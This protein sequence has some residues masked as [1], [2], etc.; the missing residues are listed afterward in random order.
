MPASRTTRTRP[1]S[2]S[3]LQPGDVLVL[4][5]DSSKVTLAVLVA[6][7]NPVCA[8]QYELDAPTEA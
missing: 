5:G 4:E 3:T 1:F 2:L 7:I 8:M 6:G